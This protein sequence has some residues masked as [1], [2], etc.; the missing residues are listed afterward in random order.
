ML[1]NERPSDECVYIKYTQTHKHTN[2]I[3][4]D[5]P[6]SI[7]RNEIMSDSSFCLTKIDRTGLT[8]LGLNLQ[9]VFTFDYLLILHN[10]TTHNAGSLSTRSSVLVAVTQ[11]ETSFK[12]F[13]LFD[14]VILYLLTMP[15][16]FWVSGLAHGETPRQM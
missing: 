4:R 10:L 14:T 6:F 3:S 13:I 9:F 11:R 15:I 5:K 7:C 2:A 1:N 12:I 16:P 8:E